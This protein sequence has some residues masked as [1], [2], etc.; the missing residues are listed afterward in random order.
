[1]YIHL[2]IS[3]G[4]NQCLILLKSFNNDRTVFLVCYD[5]NDFA[6]VVNIMWHKKCGWWTQ[7][8]QIGQ[9][10]NKSHEGMRINSLMTRPQG[11]LTTEGIYDKVRYISK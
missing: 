1:V 11:K 5:F 7:W 9:W 8:K 3:N 4:S 10:A 6:R 2:L